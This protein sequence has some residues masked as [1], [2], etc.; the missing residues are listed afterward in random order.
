MNT[1]PKRYPIINVKWVFVVLGLLLFFPIHHLAAS[2][3]DSQEAVF[4]IRVNNE[5]MKSVLDKIS[6]ASGYEIVVKTELEDANVSIQLSN[7]T[8]YEAIP[9]VL[10]KHNHIAIW[11]EG[12]KKLVLYVLA[13]KGPP[14]SISGGKRKYRP[15][16]K[17]IRD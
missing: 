9:R 11:V 13:G 14:V 4:S 10:Q 8:I 16:T 5:P 1:L 2:D 15:S 7:V 3:K 12:E 17:T 6:E